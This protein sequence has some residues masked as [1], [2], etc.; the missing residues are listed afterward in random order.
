MNMS[1][2]HKLVS[3]NAS[4]LI[5]VSFGI[6][7]SIFF[8]VTFIDIRDINNY[9]SSIKSVLCNVEICNEKYL[10]L[11]Y[12]NILTKFNNSIEN[13]ELYSSLCFKIYSDDPSLLLHTK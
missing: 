6:I 11:Y 1:Y 13:K 4:N 10:T 8:S 7:L 3:Y 2:I 5:L 9:K 12:D